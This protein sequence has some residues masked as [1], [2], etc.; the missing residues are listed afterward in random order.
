MK[1]KEDI[2]GIYNQERKV[3][4]SNH[5]GIVK[6]GNMKHPKTSLERH[7]DQEKYQENLPEKHREKIIQEKKQEIIQEQEEDIK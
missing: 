3:E 2:V 7:Q 5:P 6:N 4:A 1:D